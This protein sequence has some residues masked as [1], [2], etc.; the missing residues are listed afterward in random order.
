MRIGLKSVPKNIKLD[1]ITS[2]NLTNI[3]IH[4]NLIKISNILGFKTHFLDSVRKKTCQMKSKSIGVRSE[5][6][7]LIGSAYKNQYVP[8]DTKLF[9]NSNSGEI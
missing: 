4:H 5:T 7:F 3:E 9:L 8:K 6:Q 1:T 2:F